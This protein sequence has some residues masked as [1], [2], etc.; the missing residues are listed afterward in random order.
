MVT[1]TQAGPPNS[2]R[3][4][5]KHPLQLG[6]CFD[7]IDIHGNH[8]IYDQNLLFLLIQDYNVRAIHSHCIL[9]LLCHVIGDQ[10]V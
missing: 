2:D 7:H 5:L 8:D 9:H 3:L 4:Y 6:F 1:H 10:Q